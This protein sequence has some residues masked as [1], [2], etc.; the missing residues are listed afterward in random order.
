MKGFFVSLAALFATP[1][2]CQQGYENN[3]P[4][5]FPIDALECHCADGIQ[6]TI[7][8]C[9]YLPGQRD[10]QQGGDFVR[11]VFLFFQPLSNLS[12]S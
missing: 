5:T 12:R 9:L 3:W 10:I 2:V 1:A 7:N 11:L 4:H 6:N 8:S